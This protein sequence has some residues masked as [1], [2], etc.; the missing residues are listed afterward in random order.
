MKKLIINLFLFIF[1]LFFSLIIVL[2]TTGIET[3]K[4]NKI[5]S[6]KAS[7]TK[8]IFLKLNTINFKIDCNIHILDKFFNGYVEKGTI[9]FK[10]SYLDLT[11]IK[12]EKIFKRESDIYILEVSAVYHRG[13]V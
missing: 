7:Q 10:N 5:I 2:S 1:V 9:L 8:N 13:N 3:N 4:F 12:I 6:D 11:N